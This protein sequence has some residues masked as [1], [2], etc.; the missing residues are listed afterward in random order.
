VDAPSSPAAER[1]LPTSSPR[2]RVKVTDE[3]IAKAEKADSAHCMI[4]DAIR[5]QFP[6]F[7]HIQV[8]L[9]TIRFSDPKKGVRYAYLTPFGAA[10]QLV[11]FDQGRHSQSFEFTVSRA[12]QISRF[13]SGTRTTRGPIEGI[14]L[15]KSSASRPT[16]IG[17]ELVP[18]SVLVGH[19]TPRG[20]V[21]KPRSVSPVATGNFTSQGN[22][23]QFGIKALDQKVFRDPPEQ[24]AGE[25]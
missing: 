25:R 15:E 4:A 17:G 24:P 9:R 10:A 7:Q 5:H 23:R 13:Q 6:Q 20:G 21:R 8:D 11:N 14:S 3:I 12:M 1:P 2:L 16:V 19:A 18:H 22:R